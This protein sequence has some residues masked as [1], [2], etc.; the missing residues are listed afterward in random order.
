MRRDDDGVVVSHLTVRTM[1]SFWWWH[2][3]NL[4]ALLAKIAKYPLFIVYF[5]VM[6]M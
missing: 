5:Y 3:I 4:F 6:G 2:V 1:P